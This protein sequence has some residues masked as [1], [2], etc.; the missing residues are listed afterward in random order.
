MAVAAA[1]TA[2]P[3]ALP[4]ARAQQ[5]LA[6][7]DP[8]TKIDGSTATAARK[9]IEKAGYSKITDLRKG[10]DNAWHGKAEKDGQA[11]NV[12]LNPQGLVLQEG[13]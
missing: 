9:K 1:L 11:V 7:C 10:C 12:V 2:V 4:I 3:A 8:G 5:Q 13:D 6:A